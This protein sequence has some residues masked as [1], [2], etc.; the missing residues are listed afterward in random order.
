MKPEK[1]ETDLIKKLKNPKQ[2]NKAFEDLL[3]AYQERLYWHI[4]KIVLTHD[5]ANDVLQN[6]FVRVYNGIGNFKGNSTLHTWM[7]R[8]AFNE[9]IRFL[10]KNKIKPAFNQNG[11][12]N[13]YLNN[14]TQDAY[15]DGEEVQLKLHAIISRLSEKQQRV[16]Q[17]KYFDDLSFHEISEILDVSENT[18]KSSY[19]SAVKTIE[20]E[21][22]CDTI[23]TN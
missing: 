18:L 8:I 4:R 9:S 3:D 19:Y 12:N 13:D 14:L 7:F 2:K 22:V 6:T 23:Q 16:F 21:I 15:F 10:E 1:G 17:M 5:N 20:K 11:D